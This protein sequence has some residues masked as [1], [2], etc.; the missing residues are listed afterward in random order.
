MK[1]HILGVAALLLAAA[2]AAHA[3]ENVKGA[4]ANTCQALYDYLESGDDASD[5]QIVASVF[6]WAQ[7]YMSGRNLELPWAQQRDLTTMGPDAVLNRID[8]ICQFNRGLLLHQVV[9]QIYDSLPYRG[10]S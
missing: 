10:I 4:G 5:G 8:G 9:D 2:P 1:K 3:F 7:G 6:A